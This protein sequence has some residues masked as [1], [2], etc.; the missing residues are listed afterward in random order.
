MKQH[1]EIYR[2]MKGEDVGIWFI[3]DEYGYKISTKIPSNVIRSLINGC[4]MEFLFG[5]DNKNDNAYFHTGARIYDD[6][7][8]PILITQSG[9]FF[10]DYK[11]LERIL[12]EKEVIIE[13]YDELV[14]CS[15]T[16]ELTIKEEERIAILQL[17][18]DIN[19]LYVGDYDAN[20]SASLDSFVYSLD[21]SQKTSK[22]YQI[23][24]KSIPCEIKNWNIINK[25][26]YGFADTQLVNISDKD[27]GGTFERQ[28]WYSMESLFLND[29]YLNP[30]VK[31]DNKDRELTDIL[32]HHEYRNF[33]V[34]TKALGV[35]NLNKEQTIER[36]VEN[37]KKQVLKGIKQLIGAN[38]N[39]KRN[40]PIFSN[41]GKE[42]KI[43][44]LL[45]PHCIVLVSE[46]IPFGDWK[47]IEQEIIL[48]MMNEKMYLHVMDF[49][50]F[51]KYIK[52]SMGK[53]ESLDYYLMG[54]AEKFVEL[55]GQIHINTSLVKKDKNE[56][57]HQ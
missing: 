7:T 6:R 11:G 3:S 22:S 56:N 27:E 10:R 54:R 38:K 42:I 51:M 19:S 40:L 48:A 17:M 28:I 8:N 43:D 16:A 15:A 35:L 53:K 30:V 46:L 4:Q 20:L 9:R 18:D 14:T 26:F 21:P 57:R 47:E 25:Y 13:F 52:V 31:Q 32:A 2:E 44:S 12:N 50:E 34:E 55:G 5:K 45:V 49:N 37:V 36:K 41:S 33:L 29:I 39:I 24:V 1:E 23:K